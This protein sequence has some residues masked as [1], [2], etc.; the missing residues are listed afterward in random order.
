MDVSLPL[1]AEDE[2]ENGRSGCQQ[3]GQP[4]PVMYDVQEDFRHQVAV[5]L[6]AMS[7]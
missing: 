4:H 5:L 2:D 7:G 3:G 6:E 1:A